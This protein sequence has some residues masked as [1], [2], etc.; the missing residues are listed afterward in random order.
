MTFAA[1]T[2]PRTFF[3]SY[4]S[5]TST[6]DG[7]QNIFENL[8]R[9]TDHLDIFR[10]WS[11]PRHPRLWQALPA[12]LQF[13]LA[14]SLKALDIDNEI[15]ALGELIR[16]TAPSA[17]CSEYMTRRQNLYGTRHQLMVATLKKWQ[18][19]LLDAVPDRELEGASTDHHWTVFD[20]SSHLVP[21]R[22]RLSSS[23]FI[24]VSS[25][26]PRRGRRGMIWRHWRGG[27][28][29]WSTFLVWRHA[30][31]AALSRRV[32]SRWKGE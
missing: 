18:A 31:T 3:E 32:L 11:L 6:V 8:T 14:Y 16:K 12:K 13:D 17:Q 22:R 29:R 20:R 21:E 27:G 10:S 1:H 24:E 25:R 5:P 26:T 15:A 23:L 28:P 4:A 19:S 7:V 9:R 30:T 2:N